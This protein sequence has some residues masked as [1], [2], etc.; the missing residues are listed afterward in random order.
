L[1]APGLIGLTGGIAA[2]KS[3]AL[4]AFERHGAETV[5]SDE[6]VHELLRVPE[7]RSRL[8]ERW[9]EEIAPSGDVDRGRVAEIVFADPEELAWLET[10]L[11]PVVAQRLVEWAGG[12]PADTR[13]A[14]VEVPLLFE[15][16]MEDLFD[17]VVCVVAEDGVRRER[18]A[19]RE[20]SSL[21]GRSGRQL[22]QEEKA[23]RATHVIHNDGSLAELDATIAELIETLTEQRA[24]G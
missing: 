12:L 5:S 19:G 16:G 3:E 22:S 20:I 24:G 2:G 1:G 4:A 9:G 8:V 10:Q 11:H 15:T 18:G 13:L 17:A 23:A 21:E 7:V 6:V 14:V